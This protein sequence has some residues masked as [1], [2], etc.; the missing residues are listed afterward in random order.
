ME[1]HLSKCRWTDWVQAA[2][3][4][5]TGTWKRKGRD[6]KNRG[7]N[8]AVQLQQE[9]SPL[10]D[11]KLGEQYCH[12]TA[13]PTSL[14]FAVQ[15]RPRRTKSTVKE[16]RGR[17]LG[18]EWYVEANNKTQTVCMINLEKL[19]DL[20]IWWLADPQVFSADRWASRRWFRGWGQAATWPGRD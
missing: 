9:W 19:W 14:G 17:A 8:L 1:R 12:K 13:T 2:E 15:R 7:L 18:G 16:R 5:P 11:W 4:D 20:D 6:Y 3:E 10:S